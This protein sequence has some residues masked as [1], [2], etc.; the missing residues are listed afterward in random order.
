MRRP[1]WFWLGDC[2]GVMCVGVWFF[3]IVDWKEEK[4]RRRGFAVRVVFL[5][6]GRGAIRTEG[7]LAVFLESHALWSSDR[8]CEVTRQCSD[9]LVA[10]G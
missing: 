5:P 9:R 7:T 3:D 4:R 1:G 2:V 10:D 8:S 6:Q